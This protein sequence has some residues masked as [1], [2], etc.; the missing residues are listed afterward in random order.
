MRA[1]AAI[2]VFALAAD[3][4]LT[5]AT[6][7]AVRYMYGSMF[8]AFAYVHGALGLNYNSFNDPYGYVNLMMTTVYS[9][10]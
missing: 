9:A 4:Y 7:A 10:V 2:D 3:P 8:T 6:I 1:Y 5:K